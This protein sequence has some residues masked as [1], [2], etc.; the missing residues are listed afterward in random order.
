MKRIENRPSRHRTRAAA[1]CV[2]MIRPR[3][4]Y[5]HHY[6]EMPI[7]AFVDGLRGE[8]GIE[9]RVLDWYPTR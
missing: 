1:G 3:V 8:P 2:K 5:P 6:R 4:M 7:D 9:V